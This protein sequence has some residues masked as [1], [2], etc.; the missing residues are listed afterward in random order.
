MH[1]R[2]SPNQLK[3]AMGLAQAW[4]LGYPPVQNLLLEVFDLLEFDIIVTILMIIQKK[5]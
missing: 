5:D 3:V 2:G 1:D 4:K